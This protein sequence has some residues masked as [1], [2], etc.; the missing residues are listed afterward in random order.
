MSYVP[1]LLIGVGQTGAFF[2]LRETYMHEQ[3]VGGLGGY[4]HTEVRSHHHY[5]LSQDADEALAKAQAASEALGVELKTTRETLEQEMRD[6]QRAGADQLAERQRREQEWANLRAA[7]E[8]SWRQDKLDKIADG[9]YPIGPFV[10]Q[11]FEQGERSYI[12][13]LIDTLPEFDEGSIISIMA[14]AVRDKCGY[15]ALPKAN[16]SATIGSSGDKIEASVTV[17]RLGMYDTQFGRTWVTTMVTTEGVCLVC[18]ST[19]FKANVGEQFT[20]KGT[21]KEH[22][23]YKGQMQTIVLRVKRLD[24]SVEA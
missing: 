8:A 16:P 15:L 18:K 2:T 1:H 10:D 12:T 24:I 20:L 7:A 17:V 4:M 23:D 22:S 5:N 14:A 11:K 9:K 6:I 3:W 13:W 21:V 19:S